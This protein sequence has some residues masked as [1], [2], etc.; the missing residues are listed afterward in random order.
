MAF[1]PEEHCH[2]E[3]GAALPEAG[4]RNGPTSAHAQRKAAD[5]SCPGVPQLPS[6]ALSLSRDSEGVAPWVLQVL[7]SLGSPF[8]TSPSLSPH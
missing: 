3:P 6:Q 1:C 5:T 2:R 4:A 7:P 8:S